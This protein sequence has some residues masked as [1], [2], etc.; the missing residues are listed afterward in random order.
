[1]LPSSPGALGLT[2]GTF[3]KRVG[4][5]LEHLLA[6]SSI[7]SQNLAMSPPQSWS[8]TSGVISSVGHILQSL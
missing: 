1:M 6:G 3:G 2:R 5:Q 8:R 7:M 4:P